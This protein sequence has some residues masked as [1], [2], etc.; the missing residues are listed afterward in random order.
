M[1]RCYINVFSNKKDEL[2]NMA[3]DWSFC[4]DKVTW[5]LSSE[6]LWQKCAMQ[7]HWFLCLNC[8]CISF[9]VKCHG[10]IAMKFEG[11]GARL[12]L[13]RLIPTKDH[14]EQI[15][16]GGLWSWDGWEPVPVKQWKVAHLLDS[17]VQSE[18]DV[19]FIVSRAV[20]TYVDSFI[21]IVWGHSWWMSRG[22]LQFFCWIEMFIASRLSITAKDIIIEPLVIFQYWIYRGWNISAKCAI[23]QKVIHENTQCKY[24]AV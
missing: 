6:I 7:F 1:S 15:M 21:V 23:M 12:Y 24:E 5:F 9:G 13:A 22:Q 17:R 2:G 11:I 18:G 4:E 8:D 16:G 10:M 3:C 19:L 20:W 14:L